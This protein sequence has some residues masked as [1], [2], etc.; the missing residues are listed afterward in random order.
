MPNQNLSNDDKISVV[1][2]TGLELD[3]SINDIIKDEK[4][5]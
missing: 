3:K 4:I 5:N 1:L 2:N